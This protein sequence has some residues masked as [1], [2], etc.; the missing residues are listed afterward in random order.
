MVSV[1]GDH[2]GLGSRS[3]LRGRGMQSHEA[4]KHVALQIWHWMGNVEMVFII[5]LSC[6]EVRHSAAFTWTI[7]SI[8]HHILPTTGSEGSNTHKAVTGQLKI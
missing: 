5:S 4:G 3:R 1:D 6:A 7:E 8:L 2:V